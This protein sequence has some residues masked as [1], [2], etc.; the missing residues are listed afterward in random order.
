MWANF[1]LA[2]RPKFLS[3]SVLPVLLGTVFGVVA[4]AEF[5]GLAF[6]L[7]L[8]VIVLVHAGVNVLNDVYDD[9][10]GNDGAN[11]A[12]MSPYSGGSRVIQDGILEQGAMMRLGLALLGFGI[13]V[14][15]VL[16]AQKGGEV[17]AFGLIGVALGV[18]YSAP[19]VWL[20]ARGLGEVAVGLGLGVLPVMGAAWLQTGSLDGGAFW[21][22]LPVSFW[23][24]NVLLINEVPDAPADAS[25]GR[26]TLV[27]RLGRKGTAV[28]YGILNLASV[29]AVALATVA[30][31]L[32]LWGVVGPVLLLGLAFLGWRGIG[33]DERAPLRRGIV[34]TLALHGLG[35]LWLIGVVGLSG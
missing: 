5:D 26:K 8:G 16:A 4:G 21:L 6:A 13:V 15:F 12:P 22:S 3:A 7:A 32:P 17:V 9:I 11:E 24:A 1:F 23:I 2:T 10:S 30:G 28:L 33:S 35:I 34:A 29:L 20:S 31:G 27:V 18:F 25:V 14:G 19:P